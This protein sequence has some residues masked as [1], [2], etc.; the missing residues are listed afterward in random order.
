MKGRTKGNA[1][2]CGLIR[3]NKRFATELWEP[4]G[5]LALDPQLLC[6]SWMTAIADVALVA[7]AHKRFP[8]IQY[9]RTTISDEQR[10]Q[11]RQLVTDTISQIESVAFFRTVAFA[12]PITDARVA[13]VLA[14]VSARRT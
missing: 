9:L 3:R 8:E 5:L 4:L 10:E 13:P 7:F 11:Y 1:R 12:F 6:Y 2:V 14:Y